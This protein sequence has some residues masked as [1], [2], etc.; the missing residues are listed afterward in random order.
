MN[1]RKWLIGLAATL[2]ICSTLLY[3][4]HYLVFHDLHHIGVFALHEL[5]FLPVEVLI[6]TLVIHRLLDERE[7]MQKLEKMNMV[8][9]TFFSRV[10]TTLISC[11]AAHDPNL[12][13]VRSELMVT[14]A[15]SE[16][17]F[18]AVLARMKAYEY[19]IDTC[20]LDLE[21][22]RVFLLDREDFLVRMLENPV[23]L[24]HEDFT[25]LLRAT[26]HLTEELSRRG[27]IAEC[28]LSDIAH[29]GG[30]VKRVYGL[31]IHEWIAYMHYLMKNY[32]YLFSLALRTNPFDPES[33]VMVT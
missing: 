21:R 2:V 32:P 31:L 11:F 10:G 30:D 9:G 8:I 18:S 23:L 5:A 12:E 22:L 1:D 3:F 15:W 25:E 14:D 17:N 27:A 29:L 16:E 19:D 33:S 4:I 20:T 6:V 24:E 13:S 26:F 28:P 7:K